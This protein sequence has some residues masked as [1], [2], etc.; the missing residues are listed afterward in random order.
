V[1]C[2]ELDTE[3]SPEGGMSR[4]TLVAAAIGLVVAGAVLFANLGPTTGPTGGPA[5]AAAAP[6]RAGPEPLPSPAPRSS[7]QRAAAPPRISL[8]QG[9]G[10]IVDGVRPAVVSI[11]ANPGD[12][13]LPTPVGMQML[14][15]FPGR[16]G[17]VGSG[18]IVDRTGY[19]LTNDLVTHGAHS[20]RV[21]L[22]HDG[23]NVYTASLVATDPQTGLVLLRLPSAG[24]LPYA[25]LG[26]S[27]A[28]RTGDLVVALGSPFGL[29]ETV[30]Q[31]IVS[32]SRRTIAIENDRLVDVIQTDAA[33]N[34]GNC[35]G[36][37]VNIHQQVIG[38]NIAIFSP[39]TTFSGVGFAIPS[40]R[41]REFVSGAIGR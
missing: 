13:G 24:R 7:R 19:I 8:Q 4:G 31:G 5:P 10:E 38:I 30:T 40:N 14:D 36:P 1:C 6:T 23:A 39:D 32:T 22:F 11:S 21:R 2:D 15:P 3:N 35:G 34:S 27:G 26:D 20:A 9:F 25:P 28:V 17:S 41:A 33:I 18:V 16:N 37:L 29:A 12:G